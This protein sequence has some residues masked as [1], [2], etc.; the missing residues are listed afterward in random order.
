MSHKMTVHLPKDLLANLSTNRLTRNNE[1]RLTYMRPKPV[2][3]QL[4][5]TSGAHVSGS[6]LPMTEFALTNQPICP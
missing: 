6:Q 1:Q 5:V 4:F 3:R 2:S